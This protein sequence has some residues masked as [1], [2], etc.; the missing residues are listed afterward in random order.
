M[1][2]HRATASIASL[3][4]LL[5]AA[6]LALADSTADAR[7]LFDAGARAYKVGQFRAAIQAFEQAYRVEARP[8][9]LFSIAQAHRRQYVLD[10]RPGHVAVAIKL[11]REFLSRVPQGGRR[12]DAVTALGEMEPIAAQLERDGQLQPIGVSESATRV[13]ISSPNEGV[14]IEIDGS[15]KPRP[16]PLIAEVRPGKHTIRL[17]SPGY[18]DEKR[19]IEVAEGGV[20][21]LD[22]ALRELPARLAIGGYRGAEVSVD[23][24]RV[25]TLPFPTPL[26]VAPGRRVL[27]I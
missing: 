19:E 27:R 17:R 8:N 9:I 20:T 14:T 7:Q 6:P 1:N 13:V 16:L 11:Y 4:T 10:R 26:D 22:I 21:A 2:I 12:A 18:A 24:R 3:L 23:D 15:D 5:T 25:G